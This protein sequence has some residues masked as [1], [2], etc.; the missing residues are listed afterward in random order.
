VHL[1]GRPEKSRL[2]ELDAVAV[3]VLVVQGQSD[4]FG[5]PPAGAGRDVVTVAGDHGLKRDLPAVA[6]AVREW[7][8]SR[9]S[10]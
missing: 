9:T 1:P 6:A 3:P 2:E 7:L 10:A 8:L 5:M 4:P